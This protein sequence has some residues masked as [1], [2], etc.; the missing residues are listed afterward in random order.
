MRESVQRR[1]ESGLRDYASRLAFGGIPRSIVLALSLPD[2]LSAAV[3]FV[4]TTFLAAQASHFAAFNI[5]LVLVWLVL[6]V[7]IGREYK[8][9]IASGQPP[10]V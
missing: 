1:M 4:G 5:V 10:C 6:A 3:V 7:L 8:R 2:V 9:L